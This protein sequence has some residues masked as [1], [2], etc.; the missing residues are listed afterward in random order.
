MSARLTRDKALAAAFHS[1]DSA[2]F[3]NRTRRRCLDC[4]TPAELLAKL[5]GH[6]TLRRG[7]E[8]MRGEK[9]FHKLC[10]RNDD[11]VRVSPTVPVWVVRGPAV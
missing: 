7:N 1:G 2:G 8:C 3:Y 5:T 6:N 10:R 9:S 11:Y 4:H